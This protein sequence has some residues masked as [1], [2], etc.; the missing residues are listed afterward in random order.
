MAA[1]RN[2]KLNYKQ[3]WALSYMTKYLEGEQVTI[4]PE[5]FE[6]EDNSFQLAGKVKDEAPDA[7]WEKLIVEP[8][9]WSI[10]EMDED[11]KLTQDG[12]EEEEVEDND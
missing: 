8:S 7:I 2:F 1:G 9:G 3:V 5:S 11:G 12:Y 4:N 10:F 6:P